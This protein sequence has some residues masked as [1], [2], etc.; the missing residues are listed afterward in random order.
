MNISTA[1]CNYE[2][3]HNKT[4]PIISTSRTTKQRKETPHTLLVQERKKKNIFVAHVHN[5]PS[6]DFVLD[7]R[8]LLVTE[9]V[10]VAVDEET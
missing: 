8:D 1:R 7:L 4:P 9:T 6:K 5:H 2:Y 3:I 10:G